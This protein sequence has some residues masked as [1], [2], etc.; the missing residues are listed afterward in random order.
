MSACIG[1]QNFEDIIHHLGQ[2][3]TRNGHKIRFISNKEKNQIEKW[4]DG[5][6]VA[7]FR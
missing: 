3:I 5:V 2:T 1:I 6:L 4:V 7:V